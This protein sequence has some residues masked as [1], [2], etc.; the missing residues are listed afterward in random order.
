M[1]RST[2]NTLTY[3]GTSGSL[4][5]WFSLSDNFYSSIVTVGTKYTGIY[6]LT[7]NWN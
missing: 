7:G 1:F 3:A 6:S 2:S 4:G 5:G